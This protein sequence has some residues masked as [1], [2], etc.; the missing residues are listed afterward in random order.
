MI[1]NRQLMEGTLLPAT[2][3]DG[4]GDKV[5]FVNFDTITFHLIATSVTTGATV[6]IERSLDGTNWKEVSSTAV[7]ANGLT[8]VLV[9]GEVALYYRPVVSSRTDGTYS[10]DFN[11]A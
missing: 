4:N 7:S 6:A 5:K 1:L 10:I 3:A 9:K 11:A 8:E 2:S